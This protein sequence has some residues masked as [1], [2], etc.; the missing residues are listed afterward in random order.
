MSVRSELFHCGQMEAHEALAG[1][2]PA[3]LEAVRAAACVACK[4][5]KDAAVGVVGVNWVTPR[6][7]AACTRLVMAGGHDASWFCPR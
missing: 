6:A 4:A 1:R 3:V 7:A 5:E 2:S